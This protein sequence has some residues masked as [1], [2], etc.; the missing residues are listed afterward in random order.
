MVTSQ[1][2]PPAVFT[3]GNDR[4]LRLDPAEQTVLLSG[5]KIHMTPTEFRILECLHREPGRS[6]TR[7]ELMAACI[8]GGAIVLERTIDQ[9]VCGVRR[10]L[11][12]PDWVETVRG[13]GYRFREVMQ[14]AGLSEKSGF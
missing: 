3:T 12:Q 4:K 2:G 6:F 11:G 14:K 1:E 13:V 10:K 7:A 5:R 8:A 9:H